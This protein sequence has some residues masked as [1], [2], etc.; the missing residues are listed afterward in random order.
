[1]RLLSEEFLDHPAH[2]RLPA[3]AGGFDGRI[4]WIVDGTPDGKVRVRTRFEAGRLV[5][6]AAADDRDAELTL[7]I[8]HPDLVALLAGEADLN[9]LFI[10]GDLK[11]DGPT[12]PLL[13][14]IAAVRSEP[15]RAVLA[16][17]GEAVRFD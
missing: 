12:G 3:L 16:E 15:G 17:L 8:R 1:M 2:L 7:T 4:R 10:A 6:V 5:E 9:A 14:L 11:T 13:D